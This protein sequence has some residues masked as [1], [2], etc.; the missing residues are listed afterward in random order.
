MWVQVFMVKLE[1]GVKLL[2]QFPTWQ[3]SLV[4]GST[5]SHL[6]SQPQ[7]M[8][9]WAWVRAYAFKYFL[10]LLEVLTWCYCSKTFFSLFFNFEISSVK[11]WH[12]NFTFWK[13]I[14]FNLYHIF[15]TWDV[16]K[17][18]SNVKVEVLNFLSGCIFSKFEVQPKSSLKV[19]NNSYN[20]WLLSSVKQWRC[21]F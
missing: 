14:L 18:S 17:R 16:D 7:C 19:S 20:I 4:P 5:P 3:H 12:M 21:Q 10:S 11:R 2:F 1:N 6:C 15:T 9:W 13:H 8:M